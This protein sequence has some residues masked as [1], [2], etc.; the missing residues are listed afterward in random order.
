[1]FDLQA[2]AFQSDTT[3]VSTFA[4][5]REL[6]NRTYPQ[7]G[8]PGQ[9]HAIS[10]HGYKPEQ[11]EKHAKINTYHVTLFSQFVEKLANTPDGDGS[12]LDHSLLLFGSG[13]GDGNVHSRDPISS[14]IVGGANGAIE[15]HRHIK[16]PKSTPQANMLVSILNV[17]GIPTESIGN[18]TGN[19]PIF[20]S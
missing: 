2:L 9:H 18:S 11:E 4:L 15:G 1:M 13:M 6:N 8:V 7:I 19:V 12:L 3:R 10:H 5:S 20:A 16:M 14:M 17:A